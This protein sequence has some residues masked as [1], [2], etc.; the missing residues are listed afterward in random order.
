MAGV[1][2]GA[3]IARAAQEGAAAGLRE[4]ARELLRR[5][6]ADAPP[7]DPENDPDPDVTLSESGRLEFDARGRYVRVIF[8]T[9]YAAKLHEDQR[10][11][12]PHGGKAKYLES[13]L[14]AM[15]PKL[16]GILASEVRKRVGAQ[17]RR[18]RSRR[19]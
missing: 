3:Q 8:D 9:P 13:N 10:L 16:E 1:S 5:A 7:T 19:K 14:T 4:A 18:G 11:K 12:H 2:T 17:S 15:I 6:A